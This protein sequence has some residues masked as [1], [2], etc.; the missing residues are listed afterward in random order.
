MIFKEVQTL[1]GLLLMRTMALL[2]LLLLAA[3]EKVDD[4]PEAEE[5]KLETPSELHVM[6]RTSIELPGSSGEMMLSLGD[7]TRGQVLTTLHSPGGTVL[8]D[9]RSMREGDSIPFEY[10]G[11][12]YVLSLEHL[13]NQLIGVDTARFS[14]LTKEGASDP[15]HLAEHEVERLIGNLGRLSGAV[16]IRNGKE[17]TVDKGS[18]HL[19]GKYKRVSKRI[20]TAEEFIEQVASK[21]SKSGE[22]YRIRF[23]DGKTVTTAEWFREQLVEIRKGA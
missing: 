5:G 18:Q 12:A 8:V 7:I 6:Q 20:R 15:R 1:L 22:V 2:L 23:A 16:M 4:A 14:L 17:Y 3:C 21:S 9:K 11:D 19:R 13:D 10:H